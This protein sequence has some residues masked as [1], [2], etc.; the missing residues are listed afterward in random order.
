MPDFFCCDFQTILYLLPSL[1]VCKGTKNATHM[2]CWAPAFQEELLEDKS[3]TGEI[4]IHM[5]GKDNLW[6]RRFDYHP[7]PKVI[8]FE[9]DDRRLLLKP[10]DTEVSLH[11]C[12][13]THTHC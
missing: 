12:L 8:P 6:K 13:H 10:G 1:E 5:D 7:D 9:N 11:V 4:S 3:E 2:E